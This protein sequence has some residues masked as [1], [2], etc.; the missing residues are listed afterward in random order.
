MAILVLVFLPQFENQLVNLAI[1]FGSEGLL[2][3]AIGVDSNEVI[4]AHSLCI[5]RKPVS[6][7]ADS[8]APESATPGVQ[9]QPPKLNMLNFGKGNDLALGCGEKVA[10]Y[11]HLVLVN[12]HIF[13]L[14]QGFIL[15]IGHFL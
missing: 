8:H 7:F 9:I 4:P 3:G 11:L 6:P 12:Q 10:L 2:N 14:E 13:V 1:I 5:P 15:L